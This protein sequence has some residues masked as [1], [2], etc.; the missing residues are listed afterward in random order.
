MELNDLLLNLIDL[1]LNVHSEVGMLF[2]QLKVFLFQTTFNRCNDRCVF[3]PNR[4]LITEIETSILSY[5]SL[6]QHVSS[7]EE[8][9]VVSRER[10]RHR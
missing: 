3:N 1:S 2:L 6:P 5:R 10:S 4:V 9:H 8:C 7:L